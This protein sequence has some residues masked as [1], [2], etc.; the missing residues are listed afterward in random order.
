MGTYPLTIVLIVGVAIA[1]VFLLRFGIRQNAA[2]A[3]VDPD[4]DATGALAVLSFILAL[5]L[6]VIGVVL[7]HVTLSRIARGQASGR[8][9]A[10]AALWVGYL[11][12]AL[13]LGVIIFL[14]QNN[15]W[16]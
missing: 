8:T 5:I 14:Y 2:A 13:E 9:F 1:L 12:L 15:Y 6:P 16:A 7:G 11:L 3:A 10:Y 4:P